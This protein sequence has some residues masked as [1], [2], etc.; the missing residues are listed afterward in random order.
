MLTS[1]GGVAAQP[2]ARTVLE[3]RF[4]LEGVANRGDAYLDRTCIER[5]F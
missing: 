1:P 4:V 5:V 2:L 3:E